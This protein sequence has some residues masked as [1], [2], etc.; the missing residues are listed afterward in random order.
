MVQTNM[1]L[2]A[3]ITMSLFQCCG[4]INDAC[5]HTVSFAIVWLAVVNSDVVSSLIGRCQ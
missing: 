2:F 3:D 4:V 5:L 1:P